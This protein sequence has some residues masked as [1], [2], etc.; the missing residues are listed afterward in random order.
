MLIFQGFLQ[1]VPLPYCNLKESIYIM[2]KEGE[3]IK[4][5]DIVIEENTNLVLL[6]LTP[7]FIRFK[8]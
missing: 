4:Y 1:S 6:C 8:I 2:L 7:F 3:I 5:I